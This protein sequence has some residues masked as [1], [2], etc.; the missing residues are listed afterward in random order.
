MSAKLNLAFRTYILVPMKLL[1]SL[2]S[3]FGLE[4]DELF[5]Y[6]DVLAYV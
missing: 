3:I 5:A 4:R 1:F 2:L 6:K